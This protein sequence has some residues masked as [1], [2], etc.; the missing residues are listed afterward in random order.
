MTGCKQENPVCVHVSH[1]KACASLH[2]TTENSLANLSKVESF[3]SVRHPAY[4]HREESK[5]ERHDMVSFGLYLQHTDASQACTRNVNTHTCVRT[6]M[7]GHT[8]TLF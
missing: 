4:D 2:A 7:G 3:H 8:H 5:R 1:V 6:C